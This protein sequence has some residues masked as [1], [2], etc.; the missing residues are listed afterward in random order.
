MYLTEEGLWS[1]PRGHAGWF[2]TGLNGALVSRGNCLQCQARRVKVRAVKLPS[3]LPQ[4]KGNTWLHL[5]Q[6]HVVTYI[7]MCDRTPGLSCKLN[8]SIVTLG[9]SEPC[10]LY[11]VSR[12]GVD[13]R[14]QKSVAE[15]PAQAAGRLRWNCFPSLPCVISIEAL[16]Q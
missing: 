6:L 11:R 15:S 16:G 14:C 2:L 12:L 4:V 13:C 8:R 1:S 3:C 7:A 5:A 9:G 10:E